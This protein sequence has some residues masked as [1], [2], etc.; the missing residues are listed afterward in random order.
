MQ[1]SR[2]PAVSRRETHMIHR[3]RSLLGTLALL[4]AAQAA[5]GCIGPN[6][7]PPARAL[8]D[9]GLTCQLSICP[10]SLEQGMCSGHNCIEQA[11][12]L[13]SGSGCKAPAVAA[14][15]GP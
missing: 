15:V 12:S 13:C 9:I 3:I 6:C 4:I 11:Y 8:A 10:A 7:S 1:A 5:L 14:C 2:A